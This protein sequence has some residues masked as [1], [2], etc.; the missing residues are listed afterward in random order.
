MVHSLGGWIFKD[1]IIQMKESTYEVDRQNVLS[2]YGALF[3]GVPTQGMNVDAVRSMVQ[4]LP[5]RY[6]SALLD[7]DDGFRLRQRQHQAFYKAFDYEDSKI[8]QFF[9]LQKSP[10]VVQHSET[11]EWSRDGPPVLLVTATSASYGR[12][13]ET[14]SEHT[15]SLDGNHS[16]MIKFSEQDRHDYPIVR[17][18]LRDF[19]READLVIKRR[20]EKSSEAQRRND[21]R[22]LPREQHGCLRSLFFTERNWR[23]N[24]IAD[25]ASTTCE[26]ISKHPKYLT[27]FNQRQGLLWIKGKP[28]AGKS[29]LLKHIWKIAERVGNRRIVLASFF[30]HG[31]GTLVQKSAGGLFRSL[32]HQILQQLPK[33]LKE[34]S[35]LYQNKIETEGGFGTEWEWHE[36]ELQYFFVSHVTE[37]AKTRKICLYIDALDECGEDVATELVDLFQ[38]VGSSLS[39]CFSCRHYPIINLDSGLE[40]C[41]EDWNNLDIDRYLGTHFKPHIPEQDVAT[42]I[43]HEIAAKSLGSFQWVVLVVP[44][45][46]R[47]YRRGLSL[48]LLQ[49]KINE[50]PS[51]LSDLYT[52]LLGNIDKEDLSQSL[53]LMQSILFAFRPLT[54]AELRFALVMTLEPSCTS[55]RQCRRSRFFSS[56]EEELK[57]RVLSLSGGLAEFRKPED[58]LFFYSE[59]D[60][61][62]ES[63]S[64]YSEKSESPGSPKDC[65]SQDSLSKLFKGQDALSELGGCGR[66]LVVQFTHQSVK[67][68][69]LEGG[70]R[71]LDKDSTESVIGRGHF[72]LSR[73]CIRYLDMEEIVRGGRYLFDECH[74]SEY[75]KTGP[76]EDDE[77]SFCDYDSYPR[78]VYNK[79]RLLV[80]HFPFLRYSLDNWLHHSIKVEDENIS[81]ED[82]VPLLGMHFD[83]VIGTC[84]AI[85]RKF[86]PH[87]EDCFQRFS[88]LLHLASSYSLL[89]VINA[90]L[91]RGAKADSRD[92]SG[93]TPMSYAAQNGNENVVKTF[94]G[95]NDVNPNS[96]DKYGHTPLSYAT[97]F[98]HKIIVKLLLDRKDVDPGARDSHGRTAF[99]HAVAF[100]QRDMVTLFL[101]NKKVNPNSQD[102]YGRTPLNYAVQIQHEAMVKLLL[103]HDDIDANCQDMYKG[104]PLSYA[105]ELGYETIAK[106]LLDRRRVD[107][108]LPDRSGMTPLIHAIYGGSKAIVRTLLNQD[109][110][111]D[112]R[113]ATGRT[114]LFVASK[115][116]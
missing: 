50:I 96:Q 49:T 51:E 74:E 73:S 62:S 69:L 95:R 100:G 94:L 54:L 43:Q 44:L 41:V 84:I 65:E 99:Y 24:E 97:T 70:L 92:T 35:G 82:L 110:N 60:Y 93:R 1:A 15:R 101:E 26:W 19:I 103:D 85:N 57:R 53:I 21:S 10:T 16:D 7:Q 116:G 36:K 4:G 75:D 113:D 77:A 72:R 112:A 105:A 47:L 33:L 40:I 3:F 46:L 13:W 86:K 2:T 5:G 107:A 6:I 90:I 63:E 91:K 59:S 30:F 23:R 58:F 68:Y 81:Q 17:E 12:A 98:G 102:N 66:T 76:D 45:V 18:V 29:T 38:R 108:D 52:Q 56:S 11:K 115:K 89:S 114:P 71:L 78:A 22:Q 34:F 39:V 27:W 67:D 48:I 106:M 61:E 80:R 109:I 88:T 55:I 20:F 25:P 28:G 64:F 31:R 8:I 104:T 14:G 79:P 9:E 111:V 87:D 83:R 32:L 42:T 37:A